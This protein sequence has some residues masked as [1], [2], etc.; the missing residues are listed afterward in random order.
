[1]HLLIDFWGFTLLWFCQPIIYVRVN[2]NNI[3]FSV[4]FTDKLCQ[5]TLLFPGAAVLDISFPKVTYRRSG[6]QLWDGIRCV[7][8]EGRDKLRQ[9]AAYNTW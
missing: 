1:V 6:S 2:V 3:V 9:L 4:L 7:V 5:R 8:S